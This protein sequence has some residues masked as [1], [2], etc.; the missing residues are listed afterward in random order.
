M[1][2][3]N[4]AGPHEEQAHL[5]FVGDCCDERGWHWEPQA[6]Q[7]PHMNNLDL[8]VFP[9]M[10]RRHTQMARD[11]GGLHVLKEDEIWEATELVWKELPNSKIASGFV[12]AH[13]IAKK[14]V[15]A[16][17]DNNFLGPSGKNSTGIGSNVR[18]DFEATK[19]GLKRKDGKKIA[20]PARTLPAVIND[21]DVVAN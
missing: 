21:D 16:K 9:M 7:M 14:V 20:A 2:Q 12:Q 5:K 10:S 15:A 13:R 19:M 17:G 3:G 1:F 18:R 4:N 11:R 6:L 8:S